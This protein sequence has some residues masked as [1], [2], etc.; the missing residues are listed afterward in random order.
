[1]DFVRSLPKRSEEYDFFCAFT[2]LLEILKARGYII[3]KSYKPFLNFEELPDRDRYELFGETELGLG[4]NKQFKMMAGSDNPNNH[5]VKLD[6]FILGRKDKLDNVLK[7]HF[8]KAKRDKLDMLVMYDWPIDVTDDIGK[9]SL[10]ILCFQQ[11]V[12][13][14][15][16]HALSPLSAVKISS[17]AKKHLLRTEALKGKNLLSIKPTDP[18]C[19]FLDAIPGDVIRYTDAK[20]YTSQ[21]LTTVEYRMVAN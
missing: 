4:F 3:P 18:M 15:L 1:M 8:T 10:E 9:G 19:L 11:V 21:A 17:A 5:P 13:N 2:S 6:V 20:V 12:I 14:P 16:R 7:K